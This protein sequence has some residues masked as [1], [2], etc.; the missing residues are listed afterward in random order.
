MNKLL[1][2]LTWHILYSN[3]L[4]IDPSNPKGYSNQLDTHLKDVEI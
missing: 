2:L 1:N 4:R 3:D